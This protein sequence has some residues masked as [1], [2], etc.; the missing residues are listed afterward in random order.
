[1][2]GRLVHFEFPVHDAARAREFY[3]SLFGWEFESWEGPMEY[4]MI[5]GEE[6]TGAVYPSENAGQGPN[7]YFGVDDIRAEAGRVR[8]LGGE[9]EEPGP[10]PGIGWYAFCKDTEG[11]RFCLF[12]PDESAQMPADG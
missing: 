10:I 12:Q 11:N 4:H 1:M 9:A 7:V 2:P 6:P 5:P 3:G 8:E